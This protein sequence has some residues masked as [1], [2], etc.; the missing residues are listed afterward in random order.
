VWSDALTDY[1]WVAAWM[2]HK[3]LDARRSA[4]VSSYLKHGRALSSGSLLAVPFN[5]AVPSPGEFLLFV[6]VW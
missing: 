5:S 2:Q 4:T 3:I 1:T 6:V